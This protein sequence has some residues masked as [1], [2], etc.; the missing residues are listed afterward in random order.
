MEL[1]FRGDELNNPA[2]YPPS[3]EQR[4][5]PTEADWYYFLG[6]SADVRLSC[7][8]ETLSGIFRGGS[9]SSRYTRCPTLY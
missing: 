3:G 1:A 5:T 9:R 2:L 6:V 8:K 7:L 4:G